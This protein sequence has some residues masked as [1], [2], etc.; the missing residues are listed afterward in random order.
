MY[1]NVDAF[2]LLKKYF[3]RASLVGLPFL[4]LSIVLSFNT[5]YEMMMYYHFSFLFYFEHLCILFYFTFLAQH[6]DFVLLHLSLYLFL[7]DSLSGGN[8]IGL[9]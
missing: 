7:H 2:L 1:D 6:L 9:C 3:R 5:L 4:M 8:H